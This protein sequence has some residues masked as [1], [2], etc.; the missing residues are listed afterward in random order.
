MLE[1]EFLQ[2]INK[3]IS[4]EI[5]NLIFNKPTIL[6]SNTDEI[7]IDII[8][9]KLIFPYSQ[10]NHALSY[11]DPLFDSG[12]RHFLLHNCL[13]GMVYVDVGANVGV[14]A[15]IAAQIVGSSGKII[16]VEPLAEYA[17]LISRNIFLNA[18]SAP[19]THYQCAV[20]ANVG[21]M[22]LNLIPND[23]RSATLYSYGDL[24]HDK[25]VCIKV[26]VQRLSAI[27]PP[28]PEPLFVKIDAEGAEY[29]ILKDMFENLSCIQ[30][31]DV[32]ILFEYGLNYN[33]RTGNLG[34]TI[35]KLIEEKGLTARFIHPH[36]GIF[37][38]DL[39]YSTL[40]QDGN[41][42]VFIPSSHF[43]EKL[44]YTKN[45]SDKL[46]DYLRGILNS[47]KTDFENICRVCGHTASEDA[48][49]PITATC[50]F[51]GE[52]LL[53]HRCPSCDV[54]FGPIQIIDSK[55]EELAELYR[56]LYRVYKEGDSWWAQEKAFY[57]LNPT[58][59]KLY[60]NYAS[61]K[62]SYGLGHLRKS[63]WNVIGFEPFQENSCEYI[64]KDKYAIAGC[65][66]DGIFTNNYLEHTQDPVKFLQEC[67][68][69]LKK[70]GKMAHSTPC[71][72]YLFENSPFHLYFFEGR[73]V[74][75]MCA[76]AGIREVGSVSS[77]FGP[78]RLGYRFECRIFAS[79]EGD[80]ETHSP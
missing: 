24:A 46:S 42:V 30:G 64:I 71:Y 60:L 44:S 53:R 75:A 28:G 23:T 62:S 43:S 21:T 57:S 72:S 7:V 47:V 68:A 32:T 14:M 15:S 51:S 5:R 50:M 76:S 38:E 26:P 27:I 79:A 18:P 1:N 9:S 48:F 65:L 67:S 80:L 54:I 25:N 52:N 8:H 49:T 31:R 41:I 12:I 78:E 29:D 35:F 19:H 59:D 40:D 3:N 77:D 61:G 66:F 6:T 17:D 45:E 39:D 63:G 56:L 13:P 16:T 2:D 20:A 4:N 37:T 55:P 73:S 58:T 70:G 22:E 34:D 33:R 74:A 69:I 36:S 11:L 10:M